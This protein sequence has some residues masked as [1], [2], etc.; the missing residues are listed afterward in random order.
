MKFRL[1]VGLLLPTATAFSGPGLAPPTGLKVVGSSSVPAPNQSLLLADAP[2][3]VPNVPEVRANIP[4]ATPNVPLASAPKVPTGVPN[5]PQPVPNR[6]VGAPLQKMSPNTAPLAV[7][8]VP[9]PGTPGQQTQPK[10]QTQQPLPSFADTKWQNRY[11]QSLMLPNP[12]VMMPSGPES[13]FSMNQ[14][15]Q[16]QLNQNGYQYVMSKGQPLVNQSTLNGSQ[17]QNE[18]LKQPSQSKSQSGYQYVPTSSLPSAKSASSGP[19]SKIHYQ[20]AEPK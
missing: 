16:A 18:D 5:I 1:I 6:P 14:N 8:N 4:T 13:Q 20:G 3:A 2:S 10:Y 19:D 17:N 12:W 9:T 11:P 15:L 7:P